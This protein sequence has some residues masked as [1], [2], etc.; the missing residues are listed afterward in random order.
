MR[1]QIQI[2]KFYWK[3]PTAQW[4]VII[5]NFPSL[6]VNQVSY[7]MSLLAIL[8]AKSIAFDPYMTWSDRTVV[9]I[10]QN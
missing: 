10:F 5:Y 9:A 2:N 3:A 7:G 6:L 1:I 4:V 8:L